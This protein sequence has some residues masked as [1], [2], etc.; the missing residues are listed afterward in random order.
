MRHEQQRTLPAHHQ[1]DVAHVERVELHGR[2][3][4]LLGDGVQAIVVA[5]EQLAVHGRQVLKVHR[6]LVA[7]GIGTVDVGHVAQLEQLAL[8]GGPGAGG[9]LRIQPGLLR[10][11]CCRTSPVSRPS[12]EG[13][14]AAL[15]SR[16]KLLVAGTYQFRSLIGYLASSS[17]IG[18][19]ALCSATTSGERLSASC[20]RLGPSW[21]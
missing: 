15:P 3:R 1:R 5:G 16:T 13:Q 11:R 7:G 20:S 12:R 8:Q 19:T 10:R 9:L 17:Y 18:I 4:R 14:Q 6:D 2:R 21:P